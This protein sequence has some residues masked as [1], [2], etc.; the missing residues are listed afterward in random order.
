LW[1]LPFFGRQRSG[2]RVETGKFRWFRKL[3]VPVS[4]EEER[5]AANAAVFGTRPV[6]L[7]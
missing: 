3:S 5:I 7:S 2:G 1:N 6:S 4:V